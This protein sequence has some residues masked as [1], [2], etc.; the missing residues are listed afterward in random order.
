VLLLFCAATANGDALDIRRRYEETLVNAALA[1]TGLELEPDFEGK[2]VE[3]IVVVANDVIMPGDYGIP[4]KIP[5]LHP[6]LANVTWLNHLHVRTRP[7][8]ILQE[9]LFKVGQP[10]RTDVLEE[11]GRN[12]RSMFIL[13]VARI[14]VTRGSSPDKVVVLVVTKDNWTLRFNTNFAIDQARLDSLSFSIAENNI[15]GRNKT[16]SI[17]YALDPGRHTVGLGYTDPRINGSRHA[18][19]L[20]GDLFINRATGEREGALA[21]VSV[22]RPLYSLR[23]QWGWQLAGS[24]VDEIFRQFQGG[25]LRQLKYGNELIPDYYHDRVWS[26]SLE[27]TRSFGVVDKLNLTAGFLV[28]S[29]LYDLTSDFP[30][31]LSPAARAAY[32]ATLPRTES[33]SGPYIQVAAYRARYV[34]L[35]NIN[36]FALS[37]DFRLGPSMSLYV[38]FADPIFGFDSRYLSFSASYGATY[39]GAGNLFTFAFGAGARLQGGILPDQSWVNQSYSASFH[40]ISP[41]I[42]F[43]RLHVA[44]AMQFRRNDLTHSRVS[45]GSDSGLRGF[46]PR[47]LVGNNYYR[48]NIEMRTLALNLWTVHVGAVVFYDGGDAP[49]SLLNA[50]WHQDAGLGLRVLFP[51]FNRDALRF[52]L[53]FPMERPSGGGYAPR[54]SVSFGQAF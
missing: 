6:I 34:R 44:A 22:G 27:G 4:Y 19:S 46:A 36:T 42:K 5:V 16:V 10:L 12:L 29:V 15:A 28:A 9:L 20:L 45:L 2:I 17:Q 33:A 40:E 25:N 32:L 13:A 52:D 38:R 50:S 31:T 21:Q 11:S 48:V 49:V 53:A 7:Y 35:Q 30:S 24:Y 37:E 8:I 18:F 23:T 43:F 51:Q 47:E 41:L 26:T 1:K 3:R 14:V 54:F 39:Y